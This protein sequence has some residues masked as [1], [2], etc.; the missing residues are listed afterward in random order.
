[1]T[2]VEFN[3]RYQELNAKL[4]KTGLLVLNYF[5]NTP[6]NLSKNQKQIAA[7]L[8]KCRVTINRSIAA[9]V[10]GGYIEYSSK[11]ASNRYLKQNVTPNLEA[12]PIEDKPEWVIVE[13]P[14]EVLPEANIEN[15]KEIIKHFRS[16]GSGN[17]ENYLAE[18]PHHYDAV[19]KYYYDK[20]YINIDS[21]KMNIWKFF[22]FG[23][24][25]KHYMGELA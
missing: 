6:A 25:R 16:N 2:A 11:F 24:K 12:A 9:L 23:D 4:T 20:G 14:D 10:E 17:Y 1:M 7:D 19:Y 3:N 22:H 21:K 15:Y 5:I 8:G 13:Y 18:F